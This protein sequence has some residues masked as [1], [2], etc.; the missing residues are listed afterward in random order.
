M[1][2]CVNFWKERLNFIAKLKLRKTPTTYKH[3]SPA[4]YMHCA[5]P[6]RSQLN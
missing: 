6:R 3:D 5:I 2:L 4:L 1:Y